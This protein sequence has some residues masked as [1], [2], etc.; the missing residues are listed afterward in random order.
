V[1]TIVIALSGRY[2]QILN[3]V[4]AMDFLFFGLTASTLF[5]FRRRVARGEMSGSGYGVPGHPVTTAIF[6][7]ICW[8]VVAN[9]IYRYPDNSVIGFVL[10]LA[11]IP[12]YWFWSRG[13]RARSAAV[14]KQEGN[15]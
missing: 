6:I 5:V 14:R 15:P 2:E 13:V 7:A 12:V 10:L 1:L 4:V 9:T 8:W 3:Y 11:G